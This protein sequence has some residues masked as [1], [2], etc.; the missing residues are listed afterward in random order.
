MGGIWQGGDS[1]G[2]VDSLLYS[3]TGMA[4]V[5]FALILLALAIIVLTKILAAMGLGANAAVKKETKAA[6]TQ[7]AVPSAS[8]SAPRVVE[9]NTEEYAVILAAIS[10]HSR[11]PIERLKINSIT[12]K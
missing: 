3:L 8:V 5:F 7:T 6:V 11:V 2:L 9:E 4:T 1:M 10:E 12:K